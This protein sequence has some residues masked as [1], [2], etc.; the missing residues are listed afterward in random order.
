MLRL[1]PDQAAYVFPAEILKAYL[2]RVVE[3]T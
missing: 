1:R 3:K 2:L